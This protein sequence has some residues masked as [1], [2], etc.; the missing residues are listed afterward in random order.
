MVGVFDGT[1][2]TRNLTALQVAVF[3]GLIAQHAE[4]RVYAVAPQARIALAHSDTP[5][6]LSELADHVRSRRARAARRK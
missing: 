4:R 1:E 5:A 6:R 2:G 3:N